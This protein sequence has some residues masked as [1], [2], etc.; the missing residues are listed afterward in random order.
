MW[1]HVGFEPLLHS[2]NVMCSQVTLHGPIDKYIDEL[3]TFVS[4][5]GWWVSKTSPTNFIQLL[6]YLL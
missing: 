4:R 5:M 6:C 2:A 3:Q 1:T